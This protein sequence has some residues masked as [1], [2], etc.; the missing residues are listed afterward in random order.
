M[1][2]FFHTFDNNKTLKDKSSVLIY[3]QLLK[4]FKYYMIGKVL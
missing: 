1:Y 2:I 4:L 3:V